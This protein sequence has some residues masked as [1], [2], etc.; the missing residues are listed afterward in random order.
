MTETRPKYPRLGVALDVTVEAGGTQWRGR[1]INLSPDAVKIRWPGEPAQLKP[2]TDVRLRFALP[3]REF[4]FWLAASVAQTSP[5]STVLWFVDPDDQQFRRLKDL[6]DS[7]LQREWEQVLDE[8]VVLTPSGAGTAGLQRTSAPSPE[9]PSPEPE[10]QAPEM[11]AASPSQSAG[12]EADGSQELLAQAG[13][14]GLHF[15]SDAVFS[16]QWKEFLIGLGSEQSPKS[17][18][19]APKSP[20]SA[21]TSKKWTSRGSTDRGSSKG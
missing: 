15:P 21:P 20:P 8:L 12:S 3:D 2:G 6:L 17:P 19:R 14:D 9:P 13:L 1:I 18:T 11:A 10:E 5:Q 4:P 7:L 16:S